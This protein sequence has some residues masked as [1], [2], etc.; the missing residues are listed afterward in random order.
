MR[1]TICNILHATFVA[2]FT[3][4]SLCILYL[5]AFVSIT[6]ITAVQ[7]FMVFDF[8][9]L[10]MWAVM[11]HFVVRS[12]FVSMMIMPLCLW[13]STVMPFKRFAIFVLTAQVAFGV[14]LFLV[15][16]DA[17]VWMST[18]L[19]SISVSSYWTIFHLMMS[20]SVS[21]HNS[22]NEV[23]M[24]D[25]GITAGVLLGSILG[26]LA[27]TYGLGVQ[28]FIMGTVMMF[29]GTLIV[30][31][32]VYQKVQKGEFALRFLGEGET[33]SWHTVK[34]QGKNIY[35]T[36]YEGAFQVV[37]DFLAPVWLKLMSVSALGVGIL[38]AAKI[39]LKLVVSPIVGHFANQASQSDATHSH[40]LEIGLALKCAGWLP[41]LFMQNPMLY[42][43][44]SLFWTGGQ[45]FFSIGLASRWYKQRS[46]FKLALREFSLGLGRL[47]A[48]LAA[49]PLLYW[50]MHSY[51]V[52][53]IMLSTLML[54]TTSFGK[55]IATQHMSPLLM[56]LRRA[57]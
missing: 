49:V 29:I 44:S 18:L 50:S 48:T 25:A 2:P 57:A 33:L 56:R 40:D 19:F 15:G 39:G 10:G 1:S 51:I 24:A 28:T 52:F 26:G 14:M 22:A 43:F 36:A 30:S 7:L 55:S 11:E 42:A 41:W 12:L 5:G 4:L 31:I 9:S 34:G 45:H 27:L 6:G 53:S 8:A 3:S 47:M 23:C 16:Q 13:L 37:A 32:L 54:F 21:D 46:V 20:F 17:P 35:S 38:S